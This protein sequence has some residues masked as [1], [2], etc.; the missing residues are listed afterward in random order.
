VEEAHEV[1]EGAAADA[2]EAVPEEAEAVAHRETCAGEGP[3]KV[4]PLRTTQ[5]P[6][7]GGWVE[8]LTGREEQ[9]GPW[10]VLTAQKAE[11]GSSCTRMDRNR[12]HPRHGL[13]LAE[14]RAEEVEHHE[15][16]PLMA[17]LAVVVE[18]A[19]ELYG[20]P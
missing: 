20:E 10:F 5:Q 14:G 17:C 6:L 9:L 2:D 4:R 13:E 18:E 12:H 8:E 7:T 3:R 1:A 11:A 16:R 19:A 15:G